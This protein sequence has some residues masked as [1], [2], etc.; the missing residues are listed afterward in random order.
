MQLRAMR[1][2]VVCMDDLHDD[3]IRLIAE[4]L[5]AETFARFGIT[6]KRHFAIVRDVQQA[7]PFVER[8]VHAFQHARTPE[9]TFW[10]FKRFGTTS[11]AIAGEA[12][13]ITHDFC[14]APIG[15]LRLRGHRCHWSPRNGHGCKWTLGVLEHGRMTT[16]VTVIVYERHMAW[17]AARSA[18]RAI[19]GDMP[20]SLVLTLSIRLLGLHPTFHEHS[21]V[22]MATAYVYHNRI[23]T[24]RLGARDAAVHR[25][26]G[27]LGL[28]IEN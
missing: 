21:R 6:C 11:I 12:Q 27:A 23:N 28:G 5:D 24:Q 9:D 2:G 4:N 15:T 14:T 8:V 17:L 18:V 22:G 19:D 1:T 13:S 16:S 25:W 3:L 26:L 20:W 10:F 7:K